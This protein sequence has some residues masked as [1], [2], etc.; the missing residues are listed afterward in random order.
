M[1]V[2]ESTTAR[3]GGSLRLWARIGGAAHLRTGSRSDYRAVCCA[4]AGSGGGGGGHSRALLSGDP[5]TDPN[6]T[7]LFIGGI[8]SNM[9]TA[10]DLHMLFAPLGNVRL[11]WCLCT[12]LSPLQVGFVCTSRLR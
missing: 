4:F 2:V 8:D 7:M 12:Q 1:R 3:H 6:N 9:V 10:Q 11:R 5:A